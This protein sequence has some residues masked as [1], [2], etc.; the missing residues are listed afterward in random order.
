MLQSSRI[1]REREVR[2][3]ILKYFFLYH[4][5]GNSKLMLVFT[6]KDGQSKRII[7]L[8]VTKMRLFIGDQKYRVISY[9]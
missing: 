8:Y 3:A 1:A 9:L 4:F 5:L 7:F 6:I 2:G